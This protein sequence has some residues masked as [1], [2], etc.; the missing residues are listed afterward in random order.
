MRNLQKYWADVRKLA[1]DLPEWV[2]VVSSANPSAIAQVAA[3]EAAKL[4]L[5]GSH[6]QATDDEVGAHL[7]R[8][9]AARR[10]A[11]QKDLRRKGIAVVPVSSK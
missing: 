1:N 2:W 11:F 8:E 3:G 4:L 6:R 7:D 10:D 9:D 5:S